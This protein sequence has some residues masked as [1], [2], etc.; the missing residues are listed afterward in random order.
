MKEYHKIDAIFKRDETTKKVI[1]EYRNEEVEFLKDCIWQFTEK[2]DGTN[3]RVHWDGHRVEFGGRTDK[4]QIPV[5]LVNKLNELFGGPANEELFEQKFGEADVIL[6]GEG[7]GPKIQNGA[8]YRD[9]VSFILF[10]AQVGETYLK[11]DAIE[12]IA[13]YFNIDIIPILFEGTLTKGIEYVKKHPQSV[14]AKNGA[15][16][17]GVVAR[18]KVELRTRMGKRIIVKIKWEDMKDLL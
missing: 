18:P 3:I 17:E 11:R 12:D 14:I 8:F 16:M 1:E 15:M 10:D 4:A 2:V 5:H 6:Y 9:D 7:Y 13:I